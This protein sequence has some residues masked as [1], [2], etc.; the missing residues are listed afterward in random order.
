[1]LHGGPG[2]NSD[3]L[4][5]LEALV[6]HG[7]TVIRYDQLGCGRS[8]Y[9][10]GMAVDGFDPFLREID[11]LRD[12][13]G[14]ERVHILGH[15]W[16]GMLALEYMLSSPRGVAGL[17][18][19]SAPYNV[20]MWEEEMSRLRSELPEK[21]DAALRRCEAHFGSEVSEPKERKGQSEMSLR[22]GARVLQTGYRAG[23]HPLAQATARV[24]SKIPVLRGASYQV[25]Q[26]EFLRRHVCRLK[27]PP[28]QLF[29]SQVGVN[30]D[31][32]VGLWGPSEFY[33]TGSL[34][35]WDVSGRLAAITV[36]T[37]VTSGRFDEAT[38]T[39]MDQLHRSIPNSEWAIFERSAHVAHLEEPHEYLDTVQRFFSL[40]D[41]QP[42]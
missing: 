33:A 10:Q 20:A 27:N 16:G 29:R 9:G 25:L 32:Y 31:L 6:D 40:A 3:Y 1:M 36:P 4:A 15:S 42:K 17:V 5:P 7:R 35:P 39:Q 8:T 38:P 12:H 18:L 19:A 2:L 30:K 37:L 21:N 11:A 13:L 14:L 24:A 23:C 22:V 41:S 28:V 26:L 34:R